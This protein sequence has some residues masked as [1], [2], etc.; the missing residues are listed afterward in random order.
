MNRDI[1]Q[2]LGPRIRVRQGGI[3]ECLRLVR[4]VHPRACMEG[5]TGFERS[6]WNGRTLVA[7]AW[8][9]RPMTEDFW[10][11]IAAATPEEASG[12][13]QGPAGVREVHASIARRYGEVLAAHDFA[14]DP[15]STGA[16]HLRWM[17]ATVADMP[18]WPDD[19]AGRWLGFVQ[20]VM[21]VRGLLEVD[22]ERRATRPMFHAAYGRAVPTLGRT[23]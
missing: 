10:L 2:D 12:P 16:A 23:P 7:H 8:P 6:F 19:K 11:R 3:D 4:A 20:G 14:D 22:A 21:A 1:H 9:L 18:D 17:C 13:R 5:S 15:P